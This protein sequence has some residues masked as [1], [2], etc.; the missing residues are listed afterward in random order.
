[1]QPNTYRPIQQIRDTQ[2]I[3]AA[4][5][6]PSGEAYVVG[7]NSKALK[8]C[9]YP[10]LEE[11][12]ELLECDGLLTEP[13]IS[14]TCLHIHCASVYCAS[15]NPTGN[16]L[17]TGSN[18]QIVHVIK[19]NPIRHAPEG[20]EY[21]LSMHSGTVRD[22]CF[23]HGDDPNASSKLL[24][25]GAG[26]YEIHLTDC[27]VMKPVQTFAGHES[28]V[29]SLTSCEDSTDLFVSGSLD[30]TIRLWDVRM[31]SAVCKI[32]GRRQASRQI[33]HH[34][35]Q[36]ITADGDTSF[37]L[38]QQNENMV[39]ESGNANDNKHH[40]DDASNRDS[41]NHQH[42]HHQA[43]E[44]VFRE[45]QHEQLD[46]I[47]SKATGVPVGVVRLDPSGRLLVSGHQ[48]GSCMLYDIRASRVIQ[49]FQAHATEIRTLGFSPNSYYLLTGCYDGTVKLT[50]LQG[51]L[52]QP[53]PG[54]EVAEL[55]DKVV[56]VAWHPNDYNFVT[57]CANGSATLWTIPDF[58]DWRDSIVMDTSSII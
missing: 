24:S 11:Q 22:V 29:M 8:I 43:G 16:L 37:E 6:H 50:D 34:Q 4:C 25:A 15:F 7:T 30:G 41:E 44:Q 49:L 52:M 57:T 38:F 19:Y 36:N 21:K 14:F 9:K 2:P 20:S 31:R 17:A 23:L 54:V 58:V 27:N 10:S 51:H 32:V 39:A 35:R 5:F 12:R 55:D 46:E 45:P 18:D 28:T 56:Q 40:N 13:E 26:E 47:P 3:R 53:L 48:D 42:H 33:H 1:M